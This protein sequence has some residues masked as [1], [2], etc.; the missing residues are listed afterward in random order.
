MKKIVLLSLMALVAV[1]VLGQTG[2]RL[3]NRRYQNEIRDS[4]TEVM[5]KRQRDM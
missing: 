1:P 3:L 2:E 4:L 5:V